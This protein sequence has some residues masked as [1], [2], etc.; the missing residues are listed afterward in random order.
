MYLIKQS[1]E[2]VATAPLFI[3][4]TYFFSDWEVKIYLFVYSISKQ[5]HDY[6]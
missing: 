3:Y 4:F 6:Q 5:E 1:K 2:T